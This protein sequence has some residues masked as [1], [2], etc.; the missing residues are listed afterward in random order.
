MNFIACL[1]KI[2]TYYIEDEIVLLLWNDMLYLVSLVTDFLAIY[3]CDCDHYS[4]E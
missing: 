2:N 1:V 4:W 3:E